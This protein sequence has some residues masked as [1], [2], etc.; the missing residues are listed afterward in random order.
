MLSALFARITSATGR[1]FSPY[2]TPE[3][4]V[5]YLVGDRGWWQFCLS[6]EVDLAMVLEERSADHLVLA[7]IGDHEP[8]LVDRA[9][10]VAYAAHARDGGGPGAEIEAA[11]RWYGGTNDQAPADL[12]LESLRDEF[13]EWAW[14]PVRL[15]V[16]EPRVVRET[17]TA[18]V[19]PD[20]RVGQL[21]LTVVVSD[22]P[23]GFWPDPRTMMFAEIAPE[24][25]AQLADAWTWA[26][27]QDRFSAGRSVFWTLQ[28]EDVP[29]R[30]VGAHPIGLSAAAALSFALNLSARSKRTPR[31]DTVLVAEMEPSGALAPTA[32]TWTPVMLPETRRPRILLAEHQADWDSSD[33]TVRRV[34]TVGEAVRK[35]RRRRP[36]IGMA[37]SI[38]VVIVAVLAAFVIGGRV[39][40]DAENDQRDRQADQLAI[41]AGQ[42]QRPDEAI[43]L[44][45][46]AMAL[47]PTGTL[48]QD[49]LVQALNTAIGLDAIMPAVHGA[50]RAVALS[51]TVAATG[52]SDGTVALQDI[53]RRTVSVLAEKL[54]GPAEALAFSPDSRW[55]AAAGGNQ[56]MVYDTTASRTA[57]HA[58]LEGAQ[59]LTFDTG[60]GVLAAGGA[61]GNV[62]VHPLQQ[63]SE[64]RL[65]RGTGTVRALAFLPGGSL[66]A[67]GDDR[68]LE[69]LDPA[70]D[71]PA[72]RATFELD[73]GVTS[74]A[75]N[76]KRNRFAAT[77]YNGRIHVYASDKLTPAEGPVRSALGAQL[78]APPGGGRTKL[79]TTNAVLDL[80]VTTLSS[81]TKPDEF[82]GAGNDR[83]PSGAERVGAVAVSPDGERTAVPSA[84]GA[85]VLWSSPAR[86]DV[87]K[88]R[89]IT[90]AYPVPG[91]SLLLVAGGGSALQPASGL[92]LLDRVSG[93][94]VD[95]KRS[96]TPFDGI[97]DSPLVF[98]PGSGTAVVRDRDGGA[99]VYQ[100]HGRALV[101]VTGISK[102]KGAVT[103]AAFDQAHHRLL[104]AR[105]RD[106]IAIPLDQLSSPA[107]TPVYHAS[108]VVNHI[109]L[110]PGGHDLGLGT[111]QSLVMI[112]L[113]DRG[114][115]SG[116]GQRLAV[117]PPLLA[118]MSEAGAL[119]TATAAGTVTAYRRSDDGGWTPTS[120]PG[121]AGQVT[122]LTTFGDLVVSGGSDQKIRVYDLR[123]DRS[124]FTLEL[125]AMLTPKAFWHDG[126]AVVNSSD[127][128]FTSTDLVLDP[129]AALRTACALGGWGASRP[130]IR[131]VL[132][133]AA[134]KYGDVRLCD[135]GQDSP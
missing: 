92:L 99:N 56:V 74:I 111:R 110:T 46:G 10:A 86:K 1:A 113:N 64:R 24:V 23:D 38:L 29:L 131:D 19:L 133:A 83:L 5:D 101:K 132:P 105:E 109:L 28:A 82:L 51:S 81:S 62:I 2:S 116:D 102:E 66:V 61:S 103:A 47:R 58:S 80:D 118:A 135:V 77:E 100:V 76:A 69:V 70:A 16:H 45:L 49:S 134:A 126:P 89:S 90:G 121:H 35:L 94:I 3:E 106:V 108:S 73:T 42:S 26:V 60:S 71:P 37:M 95:L 128:S 36:G 93:Q 21:V 32:P 15:L 22:G 14:Q 20:R 91:T 43:L 50:P 98:D 34:S 31:M 96:P 27:N 54:P 72:V 67:G 129:A 41:L 8:D 11:R 124:V 25:Q 57:W 120:L 6:D 65:K 119:V 30:R 18:V 123:S 9:I 88:A 130:S 52:A 117:Q 79:S 87:Q 12:P 53:E 40:A 104:L 33:F 55:L 59:A 63:A 114:Q 75:V 13:P 4:A 125:P 112:P 39:T 78:I 127:M 107:E 85:V 97:L 115:V 17:R 68:K 7:L 84:T 122:A 48:P 44:A